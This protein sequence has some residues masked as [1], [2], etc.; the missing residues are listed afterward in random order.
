MNLLAAMSR[1][2]LQFMLIIWLQGIWLPLHGYSF[3]DTPLWAGIYML[4][5]TV[6]F[7]IAGPASGAI[8]DRVGARLFATGGLLL[9]AAT[10]V[11]LILLPADFSYPVFAALLAD[12]RHRHGSVAAPNSAAIMNAVPGVATRRRRRASGPPG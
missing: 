4:P 11:G 8:S 3:D 2:G 1:G 7:L 5:L 12:Q 9:A 6:G 10:F